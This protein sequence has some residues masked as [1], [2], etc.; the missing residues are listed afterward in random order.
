MYVGMLACGVEGMTKKEYVLLA[1]AIGDYKRTCDC[2]RDD[3]GVHVAKY[4]IGT[5]PNFDKEK[6]IKACR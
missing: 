3:L 2:R 4:L 6:F 1:E 5:N